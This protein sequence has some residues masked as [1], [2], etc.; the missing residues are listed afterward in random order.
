MAAFSRYQRQ[1]QDKAQKQLNEFIER[2]NKIKHVKSE[3]KL[4]LKN[5]LDLDKLPSI[6]ETPLPKPGN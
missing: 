1:L 4:H 6:E 5:L 2:L 3:L